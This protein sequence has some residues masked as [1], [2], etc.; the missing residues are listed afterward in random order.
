MIITMH[1]E[2]DETSQAVHQ[3]PE[4]G[5]CNGLDG[6]RAEIEYSLSVRKTKKSKRTLCDVQTVIDGKKRWSEFK[7]NGGYIDKLNVA[8]EDKVIVYMFNYCLVE[9]NTKKE[10]A[11]GTT[12]PIILPANEFY[13]IIDKIGCVHYNSG[14]KKAQIQSI[15][16]SMRD[17]ADNYPLKY[18]KGENYSLNEIKAIARE[19][20]ENIK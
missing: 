16:L 5:T 10:K 12:T 8:S 3:K 4:K 17:F 13:Q 2:L 15:K 7:T 9:A 6:I 14:T 19:Y 18:I 11:Y 1:H 20:L